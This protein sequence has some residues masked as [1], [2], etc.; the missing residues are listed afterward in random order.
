MIE[1]FL[2]LNLYGKTGILALAFLLFVFF[3]YVIFK[4]VKKDK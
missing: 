1:F 4:L 3:P 2:G